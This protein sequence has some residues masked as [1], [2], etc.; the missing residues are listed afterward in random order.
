VVGASPVRASDEPAAAD[1]PAAAARSYGWQV[2]V[3]DASSVA[4]VGASLMPLA[5]GAPDGSVV[6]WAGGVGRGLGV[7]GLALGAPLVHGS[8]GQVAT[9]FA[10]LGLRVAAPLLAFGTY[11]ATYALIRSGRR[12]C[13]NGD[14]MSANRCES[15][16]LSA[17]IPVGVAGLL[18]VML[19]DALV[20][21][22]EPAES[23]SSRSSARGFGELTPSVQLG[24]GS[25]ALTVSGAL[26]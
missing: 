4:L 13:G 25:A 7:A 8:H 14:D 18:G 23:A 10:S 15:G 26:F 16:A 22:K 2:A 5:A 6:G 9:G 19:L 17:A 12:G 1:R 24:A 21:A 20:L 3:A 11:E